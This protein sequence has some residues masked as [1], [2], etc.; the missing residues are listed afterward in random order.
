MIEMTKEVYI[1]IPGPLQIPTNNLNYQVAQDRLPLEY[2]LLIVTR[3][4]V[5]RNRGLIVLLTN[6]NKLSI[7]LGL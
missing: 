7:F 2:H 6:I 5:I 4:L 1:L 3:R